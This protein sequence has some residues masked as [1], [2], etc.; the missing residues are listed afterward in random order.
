[1]TSTAIARTLKIVRTGRWARL[2]RTSLFISLF[3]SASGRD[4]AT[5]LSLPEHCIAA[6][7]DRRQAEMVPAKETGL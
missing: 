7:E 1:M 3:A 5:A 2:E 6:L 4:R